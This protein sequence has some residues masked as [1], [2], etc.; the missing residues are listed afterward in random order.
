MINDILRQLARTSSINDK[1][2]ILSESKDN[3]QLKKL[4]KYTYDTNINSYLKKTDKIQLYNGSKKIEDVLDDFINLF[5][6]ISTR[7][8]TGNAIIDSVNSFFKENNCSSETCEILVNSLKKNLNCNI[9]IKLINRVWPELVSE[10]NIQLANTFNKNKKYEND[11]WYCS[12]KMDGIR[13]IYKNDELI[14]RNNKSIKGFDH[15]LEEINSFL[16]RRNISNDVMLD[17]ELYLHGYNFQYLQSII[18]KYKDTSHKDKIKYIIFACNHQDITNT[19]E[20]IEFIKMFS[21][22]KNVVPIEYYYC[23]TSEVDNYLEQAISMNY[24]GIMLRHPYVHYS[25]KRDDYLLKYKIM[26]DIDL[27]V[28]DVI[29]GQGKYNS[30]MGA[31]KAYGF[32]EDGSKVITEIGSGFTDEE[33]NEIWLNKNNYIGR[34]VTVKYQNMV[35]NQNGNDYSLR[36]PVFIGFRFDK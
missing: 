19:K 12:Y 7:Q 27:T 31:L 14:S 28:E 35:K 3:E 8:I 16:S 11:E 4:L 18:S 6:K 5:E 15:I 24:E 21:E 10:S 2:K 9:N 32:L 25:Y 13:C 34:T 1:L 26:H 33:R 36:F 29:I 20:M 23:K 17:G 22:L 30:C